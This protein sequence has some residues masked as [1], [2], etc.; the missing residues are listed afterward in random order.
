[1]SD[2][3]VCSV[4]LDRLA[5]CVNC[6]RHEPGLSVPPLA[7]DVRNGACPK[8]GS[9]CGWTVIPWGREGVTLPDQ[10]DEAADS[11]KPAAS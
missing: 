4:P 6:E 8:C 1:M 3:H 2:L 10:N 11:G 5:I 9:T 7:F